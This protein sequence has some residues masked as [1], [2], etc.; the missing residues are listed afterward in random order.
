MFRFAAC[1]LFTVAA[2]AQNADNPF[3]KVPQEVEKALRERIAEFYQYHVTGEFRKAEALVAEDTRD[4]F[5]AQNKPKYLSFDIGR[6]AYQDNFT[7]ATATVFCEQ[8]IMFPGFAG[9]AMKFPTSSNWKV[10]D[11]KW[12]WYVDPERLKF[13]F[14]K[15][16]GSD[17]AQAATPSPVAVPT[18]GGMPNLSALPTS[19]SF[20]LNKMKLDKHELELTSDGSGTVTMT[21]TAPGILAYEVRDNLRGLEVT[22]TRASLQAGE[23]VVL[24]F[25]VLPNMKPSGKVYVSIAP[26]QET[27]TIQVTTK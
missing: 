17:Q 9:K 16:T 27:L 7:R 6:I 23:S 5:Y 12:Y 18:A 1:L 24:T 26:T 19:T 14:G 13:P 15:A 8:V 21:N 25:K 20:I 3:E 2:F 11:G 10:V 4:L 22:P